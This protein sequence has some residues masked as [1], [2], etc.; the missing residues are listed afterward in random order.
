MSSNMLFKFESTNWSQALVD[1][2]EKNG[3]SPALA[4]VIEDSILR[5]G[6]PLDVLPLHI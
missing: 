6:M 3:L 5:S 1:Q 4:D 2:I